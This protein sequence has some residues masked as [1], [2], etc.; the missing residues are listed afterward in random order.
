M[1]KV[2]GI[3][4][5]GIAVI[6]IVAGRSNYNRI[7]AVRAEIDKFKSDNPIATSL[8]G[9]SVPERTETEVRSAATFAYSFTPPLSP[10]EVLVYLV[11]FAGVVLFIWGC[12]KDQP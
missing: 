5:V 11:A 9:V 1:R 2:T 7:A 4:L 6:C 10:V 12:A 3:I 8:F